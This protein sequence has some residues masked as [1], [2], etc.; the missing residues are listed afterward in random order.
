M[1]GARRKGP[2]VSSASDGARKAA[3]AVL[4]VMAGIT[5]PTHASE[6]LSMSVNRYYQL[7]TRALRQANDVMD[8]ALG[9]GPLG[10]TQSEAKEPHR[11]RPADD[12]PR[13]DPDGGSF[14]RVPRLEVPRL[15]GFPGDEVRVQGG[16]DL[17]DHVPRELPA[18]LD[19]RHDREGGSGGGHQ[20]RLPGQSSL[21][22]RRSV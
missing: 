7:E 13:G 21:C 12:E 22:P 3:V 16:G 14:D 18:L 6:A 2:R 4:Q 19:E 9:I 15:R 10:R 20:D 17:R 1:S 8:P 11:E 5:T